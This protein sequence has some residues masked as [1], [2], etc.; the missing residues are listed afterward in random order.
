MT[1]IALIQNHLIFK[2]VWGACLFTHCKKCILST[3]K[4]RKTPAFLIY[5]T[6]K[7]ILIFEQC[8]IM[9]LFAKYLKINM[10]PH[11]RCEATT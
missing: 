6:H 8:L 5:K 11:S 7:S 9:Y 4:E 2:T 10:N 3:A 1:S